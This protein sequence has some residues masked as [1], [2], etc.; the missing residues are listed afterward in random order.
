M[1]AEG[2]AVKR[3]PQQVE[4]LHF[5]SHGFLAGSYGRYK[6][7]IYFVQFSPQADDAGLVKQAHAKLREHSHHYFGLSAVSALVCSDLPAHCLAERIQRRDPGV[8]VFVMRARADWCS[9]GRP[10]LVEW[11]QSAADEF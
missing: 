7:V 5:V 2:P 11:L 9:Y 3:H 1:V 8:E 6:P 4:A 10:D